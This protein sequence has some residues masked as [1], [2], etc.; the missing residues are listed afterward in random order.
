MAETAVAP[1]VAPAAAPVAAPPQ[2]A[3]VP[4][5]TAPQI[6][7][8][9]LYDKWKTP[10]EADKGIA[11][12]LKHRGIEV[13]PAKLYGEGGMFTNRDAAAKVYKS[14][15]GSK[16]AGEVSEVATIDDLVKSAG[17]DPLAL[18]TKWAEKKA[19]EDGDYAKLGN[20]S[21]TDPTTGKVVKLNKQAIDEFIGGRYEMAKIQ[22]ERGQE[23]LAQARNEAV[24]IAGG[25]QAQLEQLL[26]DAREYPAHMKADV[27]RRLA[28]PNMMPGAIRELVAWRDEKTGARSAGVPVTGSMPSPAAPARSMSEWMALKEAASKGDMSAKARMDAT[29][30]SQLIA[31]TKAL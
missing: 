29:P 15:M 13:D 22:A 19:L 27:N 4:N 7:A 25:T 20:V 5:P 31:F 2:G 9:L 3:V 10:E 23:I 1:A 12:G 17:L 28:D 26:Q 11:E 30:Q 6:P 14:V 18:G 24:R 16:P 21:F 8:P